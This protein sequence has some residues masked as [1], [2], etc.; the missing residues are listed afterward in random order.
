MDIKSLVK[1]KEEKITEKRSDFSEKKQNIKRKNGIASIMLKGIGIPVLAVMVVITVVVLMSIKKD[2]TVTYASQLQA[3][4][5]IVANALDEYFGTYETT[6]KDLANNEQMKNLLES[7]K[8]GEDVRTKENF[9]ESFRTLEKIHRADANIVSLWLSDF[10]SQQLWASEGF[11]S[12]SSWIL[13][14]RDW[15]KALQ[16]DLTAEYVMTDPYYDETVNDNVVSIITPIKN[17]AG[18]V[19]GAAGVDITLGA[20]STMMSGFK[21]GETGYYTIVDTSGNFVYSPDPS[22]V[23]TNV[24]DTV[25]EAKVRERLLNHSE[26]LISYSRNKVTKVGTTG[27]SAKTNWI[28]MATL[29]YKEM[30]QAYTSLRS[31]LISIFVLSFFL[32][33]G[34]VVYLVNKVLKPLKELNVVTDEIA[35]GN[36]GV[37]MDIQSDTEIGDIADS[38]G[39]TVVRLNGY[40]GYIE[41]I[42]QVLE[43]LANGDIRVRLTKEYSGE[44]APIKAALE[45]IG[46]S[47]NHT[48][49]MINQSSEQVNQGAN[50][51]SSGAQ[52]LASGST[53][54]AS[55]LQELTAQVELL[56]AQ[57]LNNAKSA[58][59]ASRLANESGMEVANGN[60]HMEQMLLAMDEISKSSDE[61]N[62]II[63]VIDDIAFQT[64]ILALNA[65]VEAARA[66]EAGKGFAVVADEVRNLAA[67]SAEA[68]KQTQQLIGA[69]VDHAHSGLDIAKMTADSLR[70]V[71]EKTEETVSTIDEIAEM[72]HSQADTISEINL[73]LN[74][75]ATVVQ[76]NAATAEESSAAS[77]ELS[78]QAALLYEEV[79]KFIL[80]DQGPGR[81]ASYAQSSSMADASYRPAT[82]NQSPE[83]S[84]KDEQE[85]TSYR[86]SYNDKY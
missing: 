54:Q 86:V 75:V 42:T 74:Q 70:K 81:G 43:K 11:F 10:D 13:A 83:T 44:F 79:S 35:A 15:Y 27:I 50:H 23:G 66:G 20:I 33:M 61:I 41:E 6:T 4:A 34:I 67:R 14:E 26:G 63:K 84:L 1:K 46:V 16:S 77:E 24:K 28:V 17:N 3:Q 71:K 51:V 7:T 82:K 62:K 18:E 38:I 45:Q 36:L 48:L 78:A 76:S 31:I 53:E 60:A 40:I 65:A 37:R 55:S 8:P 29:D 57:S 32:I 21:I 85:R 12:D 56:L 2:M 80:E 64:N 72:S 68:A 47:F 5:D 73:G 30:S 39:K 9:A 58:E 19:I 49:S 59:N 22:I 69:S 25:D 52:A